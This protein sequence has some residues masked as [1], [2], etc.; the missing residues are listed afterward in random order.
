[1][2]QMICNSCRWNLDRSYKFKIQC[3]KADEA[4]R[5]YPSSGV[6]PRPFPPIGTSGDPE[7]SLKR[8]LDSRLVN[9]QIKKP[10]LDNGG[11][12]GGRKGHAMLSHIQKQEQDH[13]NMYEDQDGRSDPE[14]DTGISREESQLEPGEI[15]VHA[16]DQCDRTFPLLQSLQL[17]VQ[18]AH[19]DR[20]F[21]CTECDRMFFSKY[22]LTKHMQTHS[23]DKPF[24]CQ[25]CNKQFTRANLLQ[26][27]E[28]IHREEVGIFIEILIFDL[29][30]IHYNSFF[31]LNQKSKFNIITIFLFEFNIFS[32]LLN[33]IVSRRLFLKLKYFQN[34]FESVTQ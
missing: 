11:Q 31:R 7:V 8:G 10:R 16:C 19:R 17:H 27:H 29:K 25:I 24:A 13:H 5:N 14:N 28:K 4:L 32:F 12:S 9:D 33:L 1:M 34:V 26:R 22:D 21:K 6:L 30:A 2:P 3:K 23:E 18:Q 15:R 20:N